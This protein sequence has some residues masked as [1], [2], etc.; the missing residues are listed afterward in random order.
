MSTEASLGVERKVFKEVE[1]SLSCPPA[2][3]SFSPVLFAGLWFEC[4]LRLSLAALS[5]SLHWYGA[6]LVVSFTDSRSTEASLGAILSTFKAALYPPGSDRSS[7][8]RSGKLWR[9]ATAEQASDTEGMGSEQEDRIEFSLSVVLGE[10]S[11]AVSMPL[12][13]PSSC[14]DLY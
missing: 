10:L 3:W 13:P 7:S 5:L 11:G 14:G 9:R 4:L 12:S 2:L 6:R 8:R 1:C